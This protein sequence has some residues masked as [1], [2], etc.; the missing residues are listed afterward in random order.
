[1]NRSFIINHPDSSYDSIVSTSYKNYTSYNGS[2]KTVRA[3]NIKKVTLDR[4]RYILV[5]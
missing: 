4:L 2:N 5:T 3:P 1:M